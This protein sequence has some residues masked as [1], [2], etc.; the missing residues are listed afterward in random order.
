MMWRWRGSVHSVHH[1]SLRESRRIACEGPLYLL[2]VSEILP[3][4]P[5][6]ESTP[7]PGGRRN[8][9]PQNLPK[10]H[11]CTVLDLLFF[12]RL[13][14]RC[15]CDRQGSPLCRTVSL[16]LTPGTESALLKA[17]RSGGDPPLC[18][19]RLIFSRVDPERLGLPRHPPGNCLSL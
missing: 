4:I 14:L 13:L 3:L 18:L 2:S 16:D 6:A 8:V 5:P 7:F 11:P 17:L 12:S 9:L 15:P 1:I 10:L 19:C